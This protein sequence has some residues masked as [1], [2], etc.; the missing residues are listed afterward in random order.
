MSYV[1]HGV[2]AAISMDG[3]NYSFETLLCACPTME[4]AEY[5][6]RQFLAGLTEMGLCHILSAD[7]KKV[8]SRWE[9]N[10]PPQVFENPIIAPLAWHVID[11]FLSR[12]RNPPISGGKFI[13]T[14]D[15]PQAVPIG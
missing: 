8:Y 1:F 13:E 9:L 11:G 15:I 14:G 3:R 4:E 5:Q 7:L 12:S 10:K 2:R 6:V